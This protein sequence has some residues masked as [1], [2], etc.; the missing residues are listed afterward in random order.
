MEHRKGRGTFSKDWV[1]TLNNYNEED[2][3]LIEGIDCQYVIYGKEVGEN[4]T[5]HLQGFIQ[6]HNRKRL[7]AMKKLIPRAH[8]EPRRGS[9]ITASKYCEKEDKEPFKKGELTGQGARHDLVD[10]V[11]RVLSGDHPD[12]IYDTSEKVRCVNSILRVAK[13]HKDYEMKEENKKRF[14]CVTLR[15]WQQTLL[16]KLKQE[17]NE[18]EIIWIYDCLGNK[19]KTWF[20]KYLV[21]NYEAVMF[22]NGK[23]ADIKYGYSGEKIVLFNHVRSESEH[24]NYG[25][26]EN[27]KD[28]IYFNTKYESSMRLYGIPHVVVM[29]NQLPD[30]T[31]MSADRWNIM[32]LEIDIDIERI[33]REND[34]YDAELLEIERETGIMFD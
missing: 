34:E 33:M 2:K 13:I 25:V 10:A 20:C 32:D 11:K 29:S 14:Q 30:E 18:R 4:G 5:P 23:T 28:G 17:P 6:N 1:F 16:D 8:W 21:A 7:P 24:I 9:P 15:K 3:E 12:E 19:G 26:I 22:N 31:K 27:I